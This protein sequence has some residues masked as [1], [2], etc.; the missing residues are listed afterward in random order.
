MTFR[1]PTDHRHGSFPR[2]GASLTGLAAALALAT[3]AAGCPPPAGPDGGAGPGDDAGFTPVGRPDAGDSE[4]GGGAS[5]GGGGGAD[6]GPGGLSFAG[7]AQAYA[8]G[9]SELVVAWIAAV[10]DATPASAL[11]YRVYTGSTEAAVIAAAD[12]DT[13]PAATVTGATTTRLSGFSPQQVVVLLAVAVDGDGNRSASRRVITVV[14]PQ[15]PLLRRAPL[16]DLATLSLTVTELGYDRFLLVGTDAASL[17]VG[18]VVKI[19]NTYGRSLRKIAT[20]TTSGAGFEIGTEKAALVDLFA[21]GELAFSGVVVDPGA[22]GAVPIGGQT[23]GTFRSTYDDQ[24]TGIAIEQHGRRTA[25]LGPPPGISGQALID[26]EQDVQ[27]SYEMYFDPELQISARFS[28]SFLDKPEHVKVLLVGKFGIEGLAS[29]TLTGAREYEAEQELLSR[30]VRLVYTV[31]TVPVVQTVTLKLMAQL[32]M[33]AESEFHASMQVNAEKQ[34]AVGFQYDAASGFAAIREDGFTQTTTFDLTGKAEASATLKIYPVVETELYEALA[35]R[36]EVVP[37]VNLEAEAQL[38]PPQPELTKCDVDFLVDAQASADLTIFGAEIAKWESDR[39]EL[40]QVPLFSL[41]EVEVVTRTSAAATTCHPIPVYL[42]VKDGVRNRV[43][44]TGIVWRTS[45]GTL[46]VLPGAVKAT[47]T[48]PSAGTYTIDVDL[49]GDGILGVLGTRYASLDIVVTD[50]VADCADVP[51]PTALGI[52]CDGSIQ[53]GMTAPPTVRTVLDAG[54]DGL[55]YEVADFALHLR[56]AGTVHPGANMEGRLYENT[57]TSIGT[58]GVGGGVPYPAGDHIVSVA[59]PLVQ[60]GFGP[61]DWVPNIY[62]NACNQ[63]GGECVGYDAPFTGS[64]PVAVTRTSAASYQIDALLFGPDFG[65]VDDDLACYG[66]IG[67]RAPRLRAYGP[68]PP[69]EDD[70]DP[71]TAPSF[72]QFTRRQGEI[73]GRDVDFY[74]YELVPADGRVSY[75]NPPPPDDPACFVVVRAAASSSEQLAISVYRGE[76]GAV[77]DTDVVVRGFDEVRFIPN[78]IEVY[79]ARIAGDGVTNVGTYIAEI[80]SDCT[81][82]TPYPTITGPLTVPSA[83]IARGAS[84]NVTVP[85]DASTANVELQLYTLNGQYG[86]GL[87]TA[88]ID[89]SA[90]TATASIPTFVSPSNPVGQYFVR[91]RLLDDMGAHESIYA[92]DA[93][94]STTVYARTKVNN[95]VNPTSRTTGLTTLPV[96]LVTLE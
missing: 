72:A 35:A 68:R 83:P 63:A 13:G 28:E 40:Y 84:V 95:L 10:D 21:S 1:S 45:G 80:D 29:Y 39:Y 43:V 15:T 34:I 47:L 70:D 48:A 19:E 5:D 25:S 6:A 60:E 58:R 59:A 14:M 91:A 31:G 71:A 56:Y 65:A 38:L 3:L 37:Q 61:G 30:T 9:T 46:D 78:P 4:D 54:P 53:T 74:K 17:Q 81:A 33:K 49:Q 73:R 42:Q 24:T 86:T 94:F 8:D 76:E 82:E 67:I 22:A 89:T 77:N 44:E 90:G 87:V 57:T 75:D 69:H 11:G 55:V 88:L 12:Q 66:D 92:Y 64:D 79:F 26:L 2:R 62:V 18:D 85:V 52:T 51:A 16:V 32:Q 41:P 23:A 27:L 50:P 96:A 20:K 93:S 36:L 7:I